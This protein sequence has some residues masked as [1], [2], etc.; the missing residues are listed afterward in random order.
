M[1]GMH[2]TP[3]TEYHVLNIHLNFKSG[4]PTV[5]DI[6]EPD[7]ILP[8]TM[9]SMPEPYVTPGAYEI[10]G[11][12]WKLFDKESD[13]ESHINGMEITPTTDPLYLYQNN[14]YLAYYA[15]TYL[16]ET[17][18][19]H[20]PVH[21]ANYHDL[22][23]VMDDK[24]HHYYIDHKD[25]HEKQKVE[26]KIY[27]NDYKTDDPETSKNGLDLFKKL[28]DLSLL[29][30]SPTEST[31]PLYGHNTLNE[32]VKGGNKLEFFMRTDID[33]PDNPET[34]DWTPIGTDDVC[35]KGTLHG[36][37]HTISGLDHS[38]FNNLCGSV[39]NLGVTG[40]FNT[41]GVVNKGPGYVESTWV[42]S[43][44]ETPLE[45]ETKPYAVFG[46]PTDGIGYQVVNSYYYDG[47]NNL[48][49]TTTTDGITTSGGARGTARA[50]SAKE[51]Y[52][53]TVAYNLNNFYLHK[54]YANKNGAVAEG[55]KDGSYFTIGD[56]GTLTRQS[57]KK[58]ANRPD[59]CSSGYEYTPQG[60]TETVTI[61]YVEDRFA[62]GDF[63]FAAGEIPETEDERYWVE[64]KTENENTY[65]IDHWSPI[66]PDDYIFFGQKLTYGWSATAEHQDV[67]TAVAR[68]EGRLSLLSDANRVYRAPAY[69]RSKK[70]GVAHFNPEVYLAQKSSDGT[71]EAYPGMTAIDFAGIQDREYALGYT[72][73]PW[74]YP[75]LLDD[76]GLLSI[77]NKDVTRNLLVYAPAATGNGY[78]NPAT[79]TVLTNYFVDPAYSDYYSN[80]TTYRTVADATNTNSSIYG[81]LVQSNKQATNDHL[82]VDKEDFNCPIAYSF[83]GTHRMWYQRKPEDQEYVNF[84]ENSK[85][86]QG[87]SVPFT[88]ELVTTNQKGEITHFYSGSETSKNGTGSKIGHEYWLREL[89]GIKEVGTEPDVVAKASFTYPNATG[90]TK[91]VSN[92]F[93]WDYYYKNTVVHDQKDA[94]KDTYQTYYEKGRN[95]TSYPLLTA[96]T[97]YIIGLPSVDY[98]EFDLSGKFIAQN[99]AVAIEQLDKQTI[100]FASKT[101]ADA[102]IKVSDDETEN[103]VPQPVS[104]SAK[105]YTLT[106]KPS[107]MNESL[108]AG[109]NNYTLDADGDSYDKVPAEGAATKVSAF[110][111]YFTANVTPKSPS[112]KNTPQ[113]IIFGND[114]SSMEDESEI[115]LNGNLEIYVKDHRIYTTSHLM[116]ATTIHILNVGGIT[117]ANYV[118]QPGETVSTRIQVDGVYIVNKKKLLVK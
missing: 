73:A 59:L 74:F 87:I 95:Y 62:D 48:Y 102:K 16:G 40:S 66:W 89:T 71:R 69:F 63:R 65:E 50:M 86:W 54:R 64:T 91:D 99:T 30:T 10:T 45:T 35:F 113:S 72:D 100:T 12:G 47:N 5:E 67:P 116:E 117:I 57:Y 4:V 79:H 83:D 85:G 21:V 44:N 8:G 110:R 33:Y 94:N 105:N 39:Y 60:D 51:F 11:G 36:D 6:Q 112:P 13:A 78:T 52:N 24:D 9:I 114:Y 58:Y 23:K 88:A 29:P 82:L 92:T 80:P 49:N 101:G 2:I 93:L 3:V 103:G 76:D 7:I 53:G 42:K 26:P 1:A 22:K 27:I 43:T 25:V 75:S 37:G 34:D 17:Y 32:R 20:V 109:T 118:L 61:R 31:D 68:N 55:D 115:A 77:V 106:F 81:H 14:Y 56:D 107:Y 46:N 111:P 97:P 90:S 98:Y 41:A 38:L 28:Y 15:K 96:A 84:A 19:N 108:T 104:G 70:M 18:S